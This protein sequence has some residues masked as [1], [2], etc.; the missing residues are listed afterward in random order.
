MKIFSFVGSLLRTVW[1]AIDSVRK[2]LHL[3]LLLL[4]F[5]LIMSAV[6][7]NM[8]G[9]PDGSALVIR[10]FG[11]LVEE[12]AGD[13]FD[14]AQA[15]VLGQSV[16]QTL[17]ADIVDAL[18]R[19]AEDDR[20]ELVHLEL[21]ALA[22]GALS[23]LQRVAEAMQAF[24]ETGKSIVASADF[25]AQPSY[26]LAAHADEVYANPNGLLF[27]QGYG[28]FRTY[29][30]DA[31]DK[32]RV[33]WNV[34]RVGTHKTYTEPFSRMNMSDED[35]ESLGRI[36]DKLWQLYRDDVVAARGLEPGAIAEFTDELIGKLDAN[37]GDMMAA[38]LEHGLVDG[39]FS[40]VAVREYLISVTGEDR[41]KPGYPKSIDMYAYLDAVN[42][43][44]GGEV[45]EDYVAVVVASG[46]FQVGDMP[47]GT[48]GSESTP[49][50]LRKALNDESVKAVVLR[51]DSPGGATFTSEVIAAEILALQE[52]GKPVVASMAS[53]AASAGYFIAAGADR[54]LARPSTVTGSIG[55]IGMF[56]TYQRSLAAL[57]VATDGVGSTVWAGQ[58]RPDREM[59]EPARQL[60][61]VVIERGYDD[62]VTHVAD[63]RGMDKDAVDRIAQGQVWLGT[64]ALEL[65]LIDEFGDIDDAIEIAAE[66]AE[67]EPDSYGTRYIRQRL[68]ATQQFVLDLLTIAKSVG[69]DPGAFGR[70]ASPV[71]RIAARVESLLAGLGRF[72]DP[73]GTYYHCFC[74]FELR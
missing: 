74:D 44:Q 5:S 43:L 67:L 58:F 42:A 36:T 60:F 54:I 47:P 17:V 12:V 25:F 56:P 39:L 40:R 18:E 72:N 73:R 4:F 21:S 50:L 66:L 68:S 55:I 31:I 23:K 20:I 26:Y 10:P 28:A 34:F 22:G 64:E 16:P 46:E 62:F 57:G 45:R 3:L 9:V 63:F 70:S 53:V 29:Y 69:I 32:L 71:E 51:I 6:P 13:P 24:R 38:A 49:A 48:I 59:S 30:R 1:R 2:V 15:E 7:G 33:D 65:G 19:A 52:A 35:R 37:D 14:R 8:P 41:D 27:F 61:Q 11:F